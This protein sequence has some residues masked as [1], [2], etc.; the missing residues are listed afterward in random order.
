MFADKFVASV[1]SNKFY[2][3]SDLPALSLAARSRTIIG[4]TFWHVIFIAFATVCIVSLVR[5]T[6][7]L[8][9]SPTQT[10]VTN[11]RAEKLNVPN[12]SLCKL[13]FSNGMYCF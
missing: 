5:Q 9:E 1:Q 7:E 2:E 13:T 6:Q 10:E 8:I 4:V 3:E 12:I 11:V